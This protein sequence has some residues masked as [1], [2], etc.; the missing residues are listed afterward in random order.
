MKDTTGVLILGMHRSG[1][2]CLAG[3]LQ[4]RGVHLGSVYTENQ[5]NK[6]GNRENARVMRLHEQILKRCNG[7]WHSPPHFIKWTTEDRRERD[8]ILRGLSVRKRWGF[9][10]PRT[11]LVIDGWLEVGPFQC[12]GTFRNPYSVASSLIA[13]NPSLG[14]RKYWYEVW[15]K[16]NARLLALWQSSTFPIVNFDLNPQ[17]YAASLLRVYRH[18]GLCSDWAVTRKVKSMLGFG[19]DKQFFEPSL[20][21]EGEI[22]WEDVPDKVVALYHSLERIA[23]GKV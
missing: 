3:S 6:K 20:R 21:N 2:S 22:N 15:Y 18:L 12:V 5:F 16:Y 9:K 1:T 17:D 7:S 19:N 4:S 13:R 14:T 11:L 10:D 23:N 8:A